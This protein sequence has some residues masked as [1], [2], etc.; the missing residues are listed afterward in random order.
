MIDPKR[1]KEVYD[2][3][4]SL[5]PDVQEVIEIAI[6]DSARIAKLQDLTK[7][8][9]YTGKVIMR[10]SSTGR[11]WRLHE[12]SQMGAVDSVREAIDNYFDGKS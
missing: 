6:A 2:A 8:K 5:P 3:I 4:K 1:V 12:T 11:G 10:D 7:Q 9:G